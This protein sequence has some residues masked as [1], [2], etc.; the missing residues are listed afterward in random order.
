MIENQAVDK[1]ELN[2]NFFLSHI[3][4]YKRMLTI[5]TGVFAL[6][7]IF[8]AL[9]LPNYFKSQA[10]LSLSDTSDTEFNS[11]GGSGLSGLASLAGINIGSAGDKINKHQLAV[12]TVKSREFL[13]TIINNNN[14]L[15]ELV[16][17]KEFNFKKNEIVYDKK[18]YDPVKQIWLDKSGN[19]SEAPSHIS[20]HK[21]YLAITKIAHNKRTGF[22]ELSVEHFS[23]VFARDLLQIIISSLNAQMR[24]KDFKSSQ[25]ALDYLLDVSK[26]NN[27][28]ELQYAVNALVEKELQ[29]QMLTDIRDEYFV[30]IIDPPFIPI[31]KSK[32][33]RSRICIAITFFGFFVGLLLSIVY[34]FFINR[35][36]NV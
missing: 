4:N 30:E 7:S 16:A 35:R 13:K 18:T 11:T 19:P 22:L 2:V 5:T 8:Y 34:E 23:P 36:Q 12:E 17:A 28:L 9:S 6:F 3:L 25:D 10:L 29:K 14:I 31:K 24:A 15:K 32:P 27:K 20:A 26:Q 33:S 1:D 21:D